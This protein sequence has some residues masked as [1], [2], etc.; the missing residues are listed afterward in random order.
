MVQLPNILMNNNTIAAER[1]KMFDHKFAEINDLLEQQLEFFLIKKTTLYMYIHTLSEYIQFL[2][3][4]E[5]IEQTKR[6]KLV[7]VEPKP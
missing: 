3:E 1:K 5:L 7:T 6:S 4:K 2:L